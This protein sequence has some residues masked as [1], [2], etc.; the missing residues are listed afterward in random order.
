MGYLIA[1]AAPRQIQ[2]QEYAD[3]PLEPRQVR[4]RTLYS[5][6]SA[7]TE[8]ASYRGTNPYLT[9]HWDGERRLFV[10]GESDTSTRNTHDKVNPGLR[11]ADASSLSYPVTNLG[12]E[13]VGEIV[14]LGTTVTRVKIGDIIWGTWGHKS[15][16]VANEDWAL[17][18]RLEAG[19]DP[20]IGIFSHVGAITL[21]VVLDADIHV[22]EY[23]AVFGQGMMG[24]TVTQLACLNGGTVIAVDGIPQ[25]LAL[26]RDCGADDTINFRE[27]DPAE[28]I[29]EITRKRGADVS[30]EIT[31]SYSALQSAIR[32]TAYNSRVVVAG[33]F[34]GEGQG[35]FLGNEF[36]HNRIQLVCSQISGSAPRLAH[37][38]DRLRLNRTVMDLQAQGKINLTLLISHT[39]D[40]HDAAEAFR[41]L[42][43][44]PEEVLQA[45]LK[46]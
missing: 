24:L 17:D 15:T 32:A 20:R 8:L 35:L 29:K 36:H 3:A 33:F 9:S 1:L 42:D 10:Q 40:A 12:Y 41:L 34:Q 4:I 37:R 14:E 23:V 11:R 31:G 30:I 38:W 22:G 13:E 39:F 25:R 44:S 21:N 28:K 43:Q 18:R 16:H 19:V 2:V 26:A 27:Q 45:V 5:G 7:G 6:I 46:F